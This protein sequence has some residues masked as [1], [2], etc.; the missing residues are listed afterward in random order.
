MTEPQEREECDEGLRNG[1]PGAR[2]GSDCRWLQAGGMCGDRRL[3]AG[4]TCDD[5]NVLDGDGCS[6]VCTLESGSFIRCGN[7]IVE[8]GEV[9][10]SGARNGV[11]GDMC[12]PLCRLQ[13]GQPCLRPEECESLQCREG[14]CGPC[15]TDGDCRGGACI[16]GRCLVASCGNRRLDAGETCEDGNTTD[17]DGCSARCLLEPGFIPRCGDGIIELG[18]TCDDGTRNGLP[19]SGC[20]EACRF[21][22]P[23]VAGQ[24]TAMGAQ[25]SYGTI[26]GGV[27]GG[28]QGGQY[29]GNLTQIVTT[30]APGGQTGPA[31]IAVMAAGA[32]AG[33]AWMRRKRK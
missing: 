8:T 33:Y 28:I 18:E 10:D 31:A 32:A 23:D 7:G 22:N 25:H 14:S 11:F 21:A 16:N 12:S 3:D 13:D 17:G 9:C 30:H 29:Q 15:R 24:F 2:C 19:M 6:A 1:M 4:E 20:T 5:G 27:N 26:P